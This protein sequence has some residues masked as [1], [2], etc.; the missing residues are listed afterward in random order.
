MT[1]AEFSAV[2]STLNIPA[3]YG[4][5]KK[6]Q[7]APY[8]AYTATEKN[9]IHADGVVV[10]SEDWIELLLVTK[11]R[12]LEKERAIETLLNYNGI[13][14]DVP[15][16]DFDETQK[17]HTASYSFMLQAGA[18]RVPQLELAEFEAEVEAG[19]TITLHIASIYPLDA[20]VTWITSDESIATVSAS[21]I[22]TG[23][24]AG[25]CSIIALITADGI[26]YTDACTLTTTEE[27]EENNG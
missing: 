6:P 24:S 16:L 14:F 23:V 10:Y 1:L 25:T 19:G 2:I 15:I 26:S 7:D 18:D 20:N 27:E 21:G 22:V 13:A 5:Y 11:T 12:D 17:I 4:Y 3:V 8:I 9:M